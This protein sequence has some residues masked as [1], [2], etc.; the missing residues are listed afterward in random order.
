MRD[1]VTIFGSDFDVAPETKALAAAE[2]AVLLGGGFLAGVFSMP[3]FLMGGEDISSRGA[4]ET[5]SEGCK[6][7]SGVSWKS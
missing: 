5:T 2:K 1:G 6:R 7:D 4:E 3:S